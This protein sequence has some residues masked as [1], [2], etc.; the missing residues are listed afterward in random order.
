M[1]TS[2]VDVSVSTVIPATRT[3]YNTLMGIVGDAGTGTATDDTV[4]TVYTPQQAG[5]LFGSGTALHNAAT[6][7]FE[8]G[9]PE[10]KMINVSASTSEKYDAAYDALKTAGC[11]I[12]ALAGYVIDSTDTIVTNHVAKAEEKEFMTVLYNDLDDVTDS[13][14]TTFASSTDSKYVVLVAG[15]GFDDS[16]DPA[17]AVCGLMSKLKPWQRLMWKTLNGITYTDLD[18][19]TIDTLE[20]GKV[21]AITTIRNSCVLTNGLTTSSNAVYMYSDVALTELY[22][23]RIIRDTIENT[24]VNGDIPFTDS[25]INF[26][27][28]LI[29]RA[30]ETVKAGGGIIDYSISM[31]R[32]SEI[33]TEDKEARLLRNVYVTATLAGHI[34]TI[35][36]EVTLSL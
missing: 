22:I 10:I 24:Q 25:G 12:I 5:I 32:L 33:P 9:I 35:Q 27:R 31:P 18:E 3:I 6:A 23:K 26:V 30:M 8:Q 19:A 2:M 14:L 16:D 21:N 11:D 7:A 13:D 15:K 28:S 17:A 29:A 20:A 36:I 4:Y 34:Q 1:P